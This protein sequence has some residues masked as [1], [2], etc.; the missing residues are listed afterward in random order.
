MVKYSYELQ[1]QAW[2]KDETKSRE[3]YL[4]T[5]SAFVGAI[6]D[7]L[8]HETPDRDSVIIKIRNADTDFIELEAKLD[9]VYSLN[10]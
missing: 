5:K 3:G 2:P 7:I 10:G 8:D 1:F 4:S 9:M 6:K